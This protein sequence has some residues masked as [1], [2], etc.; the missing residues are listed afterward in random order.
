MSEKEEN[1]EKNENRDEKLSLYESFYKESEEFTKTEFSIH[2]PESELK[3]GTGTFKEFET[4]K[5]KLIA[6]I[7]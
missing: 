3:S 5:P 4:T 7:A 6:A 2:F 1:E